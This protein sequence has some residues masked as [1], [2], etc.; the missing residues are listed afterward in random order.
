MRRITGLI[1][2]AAMLCSAGAATA[3]ISQAAMPDMARTY[4]ER[5][6]CHGAYDVLIEQLDNGTRPSE[7]E[8]AWAKSYED[9]AASGEPCPA[10]PADL[11]A[12]ASNRTVVTQEG[13]AK[14]AA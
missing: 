13:L 7:A 5:Q 4:H 10:P 11:A 2:A 8:V 1:A 3:V 14:H 9:N 6:N 12:R